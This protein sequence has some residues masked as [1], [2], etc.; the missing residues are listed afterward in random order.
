MSAE[1]AYLF[2]HALVRDA[3]YD[4]QMPSERCELHRLAIDAFESCLDAEVLSVHALEL[5]DHAAVARDHSDDSELVQTECRYLDAGYRYALSRD[6][7]NE[8]ITALERLTALLPERSDARREA[9]YELAIH[10]TASDAARGLPLLAECRRISEDDVYLGKV[11]RG[12]A[13][14]RYTMDQHQKGRDLLM[15]AVQVHEHAGDP[16]QLA[17]TRNALARIL[18][19]EGEIEQAEAMLQA[20]LP[21]TEALVD[22]RYFGGALTTLG[23]AASRT[24]RTSEAKDWFRRALEV[25]E[26]IGVSRYLVASLQ[27]LGRMQSKLGELEDAAQTMAR[28]VDVC[29]RNGQFSAECTT[30]MTLG[31]VLRRLGREDEAAQLL[32]E[33]IRLGRE[34]ALAGWV[35]KA[36]QELAEMTA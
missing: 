18:L 34:L 27:G 14:T 4:L 32:R 22:R 21:V 17:L 11:L 31:K 10:V 15:R 26:N 29:H 19:Q 23:M 8:A 5:A 16:V 9:L 6:Q 13:M 7:V 28:C 3:A 35:R 1:Q 12:E 36:E 25:Y 30:R 24:G 33:V 20:V 2:V